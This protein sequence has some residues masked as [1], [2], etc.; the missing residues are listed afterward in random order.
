MEYRRARALPLRIVYAERRKAAGAFEAVRRKPS[1]PWKS[2]H[3]LLIPSR[4]KVILFEEE[5]FFDSF[6]VNSDS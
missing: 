1:G 6:C 3:Q 4:L 2:A 5:E